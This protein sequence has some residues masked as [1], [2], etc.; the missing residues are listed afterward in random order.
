VDDSEG[1]SS[2]TAPARNRTYVQQYDEGGHAINTRARE[3]ERRLRRAQNDVLAAAG[4]LERY[5]KSA[6]NHP[7]QGLE[8]DST[9]GGSYREYHK[10]L[11]RE[12]STGQALGFVFSV[13]YQGFIFCFQSLEARFWTYGI[14]DASFLAI[15][16][17][18]Q[19]GPGSPFAGFPIW[20]LIAAV[21]DEIRRAIRRL[22]PL[23]RL[24]SK[25]QASRKRRASVYRWRHV[26]QEL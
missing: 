15:V 25:T 17:S 2:S 20:L 18:R 5:S 4:I 24:L 21:K 10:T 3:Y 22:Q 16:A 8:S 26:L 23:E 1:G 12:N 14:E 9:L 19:W 7:S 11:D 13:P 6:E